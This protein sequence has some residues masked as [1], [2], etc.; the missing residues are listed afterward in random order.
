MTKLFTFIVVESNF[1]TT[2]V[3]KLNSILQD[4][5]FAFKELI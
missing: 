1:K 2:Q 3:K 4:H 5:N